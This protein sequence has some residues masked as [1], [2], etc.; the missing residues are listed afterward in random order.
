MSPSS[1][2]STLAQ[3]FKRST[4][5]RR[6][7]YLASMHS[8]LNKVLDLAPP[9]LI[10]V[11][12]D[13]VVER[14]NSLLASWGVADTS[15][16]L[17]L[18]A[19]VTILIW[20]FES[21]F[22]Y[23]YKLAWRNLA[24]TLQH[25]LRLECYAHV[26]SLEMGFFEDA[27]T[28]GLM[29]VL[30]DDVNQLERFLDGGVNALLQL[31]TTVLVIGAIFFWI[32]ASVAW[33][34][35]LPMPFILWGSVHFQKLLAPRYGAVREEV[36]L[37]NAELSGNLS[38]IATIKSY[39]S[40]AR[41]VQRID[42]RSQAYRERNRA[43]I[44]LSSAFSPLIR[45]V[46]VLGFTAILVGGGQRVID[47][48][49]APAAYSVMVFMT[50]RLLWPLTSIGETLDLYQRAMAS[51][52]RILN[53][54]KT[55][56]KIL[57]GSRPLERAQVRGRIQ[58]QAVDF[59]YGS[60]I[61]LFRDLSI[62]IPAGQTTA[63]VGSTG[64]GKSSLVKLLLR[65]YDPQAGS[66]SL[67]GVDLRELKLKDLRAAI[68]LVSQDVFLFHGT[69]RD[70]IE[71]GRPGASLTEIEAAAKLAEADE[72]I[73]ELPKGYETL[74]GERGQ[75]L[76]GGQRQRISIARALLKDAP[77]MIF[78]EA[79]SSVDNET[80]AAIQRSLERA[81]S[82]RTTVLIAHRLSTVRKAHRIHVLER[83]QLVEHGTHDELVAQGGVYA[84]LWRVQTGEGA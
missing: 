59:S 58:L 11:G 7:I 81:S 79:T 51:T 40:E 48:H 84:A 15:L 67:D 6:A 60:G 70:N 35:M 39:T 56:P 24:Q 38:G 83:G 19:G 42:E 37:L 23:A 77:I 54:L 29:S 82:G 31:A 21:L 76:S 43:A 27:Q 9:L 73:Q 72:F 28:G 22:E 61:V 80:E 65:F 63:F 12:I 26:Q 18:L 36:G 64:S 45:M 30:N 2:P 78:D 68:G 33:M 62:E 47:G 50:Q 17:W 53:L 49:L 32:D 46:I 71:Y 75:K 74:V 1:Q 34:G 3:L 20:L 55:P 16:Q 52:R 57:S 13:I 25:E 69:V 14:E 66:L 44:R 41:E 8:V 5:H 4:R 10:G